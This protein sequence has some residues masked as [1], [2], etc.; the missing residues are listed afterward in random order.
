[1]YYLDIGEL[2]DEYPEHF[3]SCLFL[4]I[5]VGQDAIVVLISRPHLWRRK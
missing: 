4:Q 1:M 2:S 3:I 5:R